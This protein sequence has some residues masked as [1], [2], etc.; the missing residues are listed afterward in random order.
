M[1]ASSRFRGGGELSAL[2]LEIPGDISSAAFLL[3]AGLVC[4]DSQLTIR[5]VGINPTRTGIID[6]LNDMGAN[7]SVTDSRTEGAEPVADLGMVSTELQGVTLPTTGW[8]RCVSLGK[9]PNICLLT[10]RLKFTSSMKY[11]C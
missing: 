3:V 4:P 10:V 7:I 1:I 2:D 8:N 9:I 11:T 5:G 6:V